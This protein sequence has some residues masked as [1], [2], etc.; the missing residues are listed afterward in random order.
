MDASEPTMPTMP[1]CLATLELFCL[2]GT[3]KYAARAKIS[4]IRERLL[5]SVSMS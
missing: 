2:F 1:T 5:Q 3:E 4:G